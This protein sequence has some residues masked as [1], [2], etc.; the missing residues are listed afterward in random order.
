[1]L[2]LIF[3]RV[4]KT[5]TVNTKSLKVQSFYSDNNGE[6]ITIHKKVNITMYTVTQVMEYVLV[7]TPKHKNL[8]IN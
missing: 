6:N 2:K 1:V 8:P 3:K 4:P 7:K 5:S